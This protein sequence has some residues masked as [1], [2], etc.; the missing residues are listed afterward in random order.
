MAKANVPVFYF[1]DEILKGTNSRD[2]HLGAVALVKQLHKRPAS[3]LISTHD[4]ELGQL[5]QEHPDSVRNFSLN[6]TLEGDKILFDYKL[7]PGVCHS[8]NASKLMQQIGIE[9]EG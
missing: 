8:F 5:Q 3:G 4:L 1:L 6:S 9:M 2:R 7:T